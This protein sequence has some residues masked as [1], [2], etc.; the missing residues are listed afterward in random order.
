[1]FATTNHAQLEEFLESIT[2]DRSLTR[3][4]I[5]QKLNEGLTIWSNEE[6]Y[7][8]LEDAELMRQSLIRNIKKLDCE[9]RIDVSTYNDLLFA[10]EG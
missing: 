5:A 1:M 4:E 10:L 6:A 8:D 2:L 3:L 7:G 9:Y